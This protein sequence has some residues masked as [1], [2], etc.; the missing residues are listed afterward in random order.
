MLRREQAR[1]CSESAKHTRQHQRGPADLKRI[2]VAPS[3]LE[4]PMTSV[5][6]VEARHL[7]LIEKKMFGADLLGNMKANGRVKVVEGDEMLAKKKTREG[8][9]L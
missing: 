5:V 6:D 3:M 8:S 2:D 9:P 4:N 1:P 7:L